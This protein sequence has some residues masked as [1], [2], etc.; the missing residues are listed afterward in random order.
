MIKEEKMKRIVWEELKKRYEEA[1]KHSESPSVKEDRL[2]EEFEYFLKK[3][4][5]LDTAKEKL[6]QLKHYIKD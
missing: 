1:K 2:I 5:W 3:H 6:E 4:H